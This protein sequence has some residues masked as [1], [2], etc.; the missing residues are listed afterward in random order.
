MQVYKFPELGRQEIEAMLGLE[1]LK[2]TKVYQ[3]ALEEGRLEGK[4]AAV[5]LLLQAGIPCE[6]IA[7]ELDLDINTV[8]QVASNSSSS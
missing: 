7:Q 6:Q 1:E 8:R 2:Q 3:E 5:P 4:L